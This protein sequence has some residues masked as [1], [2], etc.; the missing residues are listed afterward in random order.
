MVKVRIKHFTPK[1]LKLLR[2]MIDFAVNSIIERYEMQWLNNNIT[3]RQFDER[4]KLWT[5]LGYNISS[6]KELNEF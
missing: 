6:R 5:K 1:E 3:D 4:W 2:E